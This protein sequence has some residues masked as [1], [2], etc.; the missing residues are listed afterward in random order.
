MAQQQLTASVLKIKF[1]NGL[2]ENGEPNILTKS[3]RDVKQ[4]ASAEALLEVAD[5]LASL[6]SYT[7]LSTERTDN[8]DIVR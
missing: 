8:F 3:L 1:Q 6:V 7:H 2:K 5:H 4:E